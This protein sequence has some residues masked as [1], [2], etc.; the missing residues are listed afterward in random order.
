MPSLQR[1]RNANSIPPVAPLSATK[2]TKEVR[3]SKLRSWKP[4]FFLCVF[5]AATAIASSPTTTF[6]NLVNFDGTDGDN[7]Y[8]LS[9]VQ[10]R[11][12]NFYGTTLRGGAKNAGT[13]FKITPGG[14]LTTLH[15]F[16]SQ[17]N[18]TDGSLPYAGLVLGTD[19]NLYGT[20][21]AGGAMNRGTVYKITPGGIPTILHSFCLENFCPDG[22][23]PEAA[24]V[25]GYFPIASLVTILPSVRRERK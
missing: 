15:N 23:I 11:D 1:I 12:G 22:Q 9:L 19:G 18:C 24:L 21:E 8:F 2:P 16:C 25:Q 3:M 4:I 20:T 14:N 5:C 6:T 10:G 17:T 7:P 13:V